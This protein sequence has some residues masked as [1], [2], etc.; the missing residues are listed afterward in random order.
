[1]D[2][3]LPLLLDGVPARRQLDDQRVL[4]ELLVQPRLQLIQHRHRRP[5][6]FPRDVLVLH[7]EGF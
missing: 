6:D 3:K 4:V 2:W 1:V 7:G 5:D